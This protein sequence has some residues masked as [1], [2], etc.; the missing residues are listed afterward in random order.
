MGKTTAEI[1]ELDTDQYQ[2]FPEENNCFLRALYDKEFP[3]YQKDLLTNM[4]ELVDSGEKGYRRLDLALYAASW[5]IDQHM[6]FAAK[7][8]PKPS[9]NDYIPIDIVKRPPDNIPVDEL[10][11]YTKRAARFL[12]AS[13]VGIA[14]VDPNWILKNSAKAMGPADELTKE[15]LRLTNVELP[16]GVTNC[17]V[18]AIEMD[19]SGIRNAPNFLEVASVGMGY[20]NMTALS[21]SVAQ[22]IRNLGYIAIPS[23]NDT[24]FSIP[25]A[26][27]AGLGAF[28]RNGLLIHK[29]WGPRIR[30]C[31]IFTNMPLNTDEPDYGYIGK[32]AQYCKG[33]RKCAEECEAEAIS[34]ADGPDRRV[35]CSSNNPG[36]KKWYVDTNACY[37][38]W[39]KHG[40]DCG[41]CIQVCPFSK[42][43]NKLT[44]DEF[45]DM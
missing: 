33:C 9:S 29:K 34:F 39:V 37:G 12:G 36:V 28:G 30:L 11:K 2:R 15:K 40:T 16:E 7:W 8:F 1:F 13:D 45:W 3:S 4:V 24:G 5:T 23:T 18:C 20:S 41:N 6:P 22:F 43:P 10:T 31:K 26:I 19:P 25:L 42:T 38:I 44:P 17:I 14:K 32:I 21:V 27:D 35:R